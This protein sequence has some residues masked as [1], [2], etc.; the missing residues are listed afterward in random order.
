VTLDSDSRRP[1]LLCTVVLYVVYGSKK[2]ELSIRRQYEYR[3]AYRGD[4]VGDS[5]VS[6]ED[7]LKFISL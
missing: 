1:K 4:L 2:G 7:A 5:E 6:A 3:T